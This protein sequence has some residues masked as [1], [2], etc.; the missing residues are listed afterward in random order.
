MHGILSA[1][2]LVIAFAA[3]AVAGLYVA[4]RVFGAGGRRRRVRE[5]S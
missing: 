4:A 2:I 5:D 3:I 1:G